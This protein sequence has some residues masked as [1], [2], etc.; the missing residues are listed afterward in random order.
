MGTVLTLSLHA[1][2]LTSE[3]ERRTRAE[4]GRRLA[5]LKRFEFRG[6]Y[7][8]LR[9]HPRPLYLVPS[10]TLRR[11]QLEA[12]PGLDADDPLFGGVVPYAFVATKA[13][14]HALPSPDAARPE[15]W[16]TDFGPRVRDAVLRGYSA[17]DLKA[18]REAGRRL[19]AHGPVRLK[20]VHATGGRGQTVA[21]DERA[22]L[23][24]L[25][26]VPPEEL[27]TH[28]VVLEEDLQ[29]PQTW[30]VGQARVAGS[31]ISYWGVQRLTRDNQGERVYGG[32]DLEV[33]RGGFD[34]LLALPL[35]RGARLAVRLA[36]RYHDAVLACFE[37]FHATRVNYDVV[38]GHGADG[39]RRA[40]V[41]EQS[42]RFGGATGAEV[43]A[44]E[45]FALAPHRQRARAST[46]EV[47]GEDSQAPAPAHAEIYYQGIDPQAGP[48]LKYALLHDDEDD[49]TAQA[50]PRGR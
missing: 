15:G 29:E 22:L 21:V 1:A 28:G 35:R 43:A 48:L 5:A 3:H 41:L 46:Y 4:L 24:C 12:V 31:T 18:A 38:L 19:L 33:V 42:W 23:A 36:T 16:S 45:C 7:D 27:S 9:D 2:S 44:L 25:D 34:A 11:A 32:S 50:H 37:G 6:E 47:Y 14:T 39:Q 17:F 10:D 20:R 13:I 30:G 40:G 26:E 49:H 8:G